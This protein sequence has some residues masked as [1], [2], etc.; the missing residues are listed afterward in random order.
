MILLDI[1]MP[2]MDGFEVL[3]VLRNDEHTADIPVFAVTANALPK[4]LERGV[5]AG[6]DHYLAKPLNIPQFIAAVEVA[7][8]QPPIRQPKRVRVK[9]EP[10]AS[11]ESVA[12]KP[13]SL[14]SPLQ[15]IR[16]P[17]L[18]AMLGRR[19]ESPASAP[20][21][22]APTGQDGPQAGE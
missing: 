7:L 22:S 1:N 2:E 9:R 12:A 14:K 11:P 6:F 5:A 4:D 18:R 10:V 15:P 16:K 19:A 17:F 8:L 20:L 21:A 3:K 13:P